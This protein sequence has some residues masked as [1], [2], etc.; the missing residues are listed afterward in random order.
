MR[1]SVVVQ[2]PFFPNLISRKNVRAVGGLGSFKI[3]TNRKKI[4]RI[5]AQPNIVKNH[6]RNK[7]ERRQDGM[8][9]VPN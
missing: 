1:A 6:T 8:T 7:Y 3:I 5:L 4:N 2:E 9:N